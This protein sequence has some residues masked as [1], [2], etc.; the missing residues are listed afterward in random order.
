MSLQKFIP[1]RELRVQQFISNDPAG[2]ARDLQTW[3]A[4]SDAEVCSLTQSQG[5]RQG[6][7][8]FVITVMYR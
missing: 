6:R 2:A 4:E 7:F 8:L 1:A 5:E 3:L